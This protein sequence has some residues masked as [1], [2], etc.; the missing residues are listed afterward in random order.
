MSKF[1]DSTRIATFD[2]LFYGDDEFVAA[3][4]TWAMAVLIPVPIE[5]LSAN[6]G[7]WTNTEN[8]KRIVKIK[9]NDILAICP[10]CKHVMSAEASLRPFQTNACSHC[11]LTWCK[12]GSI[13]FE[14]STVYTDTITG[15]II[16]VGGDGFTV[17][18]ADLDELGVSTHETRERF[19]TDICLVEEESTWR[20]WRHP[21]VFLL[22]ATISEDIIWAAGL[23][24][25][26]YNPNNVLACTL[27]GYN[28]EEDNDEGL[29]RALARLYVLY[30]E[31]KSF[32]VYSSIL[33]KPPCN[34]TK[35][36]L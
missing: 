30:H 1:D 11:D 21:A 6:P 3:A 27:V 12:D 26:K 28:G 15:E 31:E 24:V 9:M 4:M 10:H 16:R 29:Q 2:Q 7:C 17:E 19:H 14:P 5:V 32:G 22:D 34:N 13:D 23:T 35:V 33:S 8:P 20:P 18:A 25:A 36:M